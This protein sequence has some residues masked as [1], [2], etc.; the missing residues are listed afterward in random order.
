MIDEW[1]IED[2]KTH[3]RIIYPDVYEHYPLTYIVLYD[4]LYLWMNPTVQEYWDKWMSNIDPAEEDL[5]MA[6]KRL[7]EEY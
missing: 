4:K 5:V 2:F 1:K 7:Y 6:Y 3:L